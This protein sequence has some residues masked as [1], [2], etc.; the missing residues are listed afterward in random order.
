MTKSVHKKFNLFVSV[1]IMLFFLEDLAVD[2]MSSGTKD[3][4][5][6]FELTF[7]IALA[8]TLITQVRE[9][10]FIQGKLLEANDKLNAL[11]DNL[12]DAIEAQFKLWKLTKAEKEVAWLVVKGF[13]FIKISELRGVSEKTIHQQI[14]SVYKKSGTKNRHEFLSGFLEEFMNFDE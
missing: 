6:Y 3:F 4:H 1:A 2:F 14:S 11:K 9:I 7:V 12:F 5:F 8:Y 10:Y 13:S